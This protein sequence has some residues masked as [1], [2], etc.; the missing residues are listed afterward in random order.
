VPDGLTDDLGYIVSHQ[1]VLDHFGWYCSGVD[2][3]QMPKQASEMFVHPLT[4]VRVE[5]FLVARILGP[6]GKVTDVA[7]LHLNNCLHITKPWLSSSAQLKDGVG[8]H[9]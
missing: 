6:L 1:H 3:H 9:V 2:L 8:H 7:A 4:V 5:H